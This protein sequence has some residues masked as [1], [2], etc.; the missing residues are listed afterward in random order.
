MK[1]RIWDTLVYVHHLCIFYTYLPGSMLYI[2]IYRSLCNV[3]VRRD[4][5]VPRTQ[6]NPPRD[7]AF[8][9]TGILEAPMRSGYRQ[10]RSCKRLV[11]PLGKSS[12]NGEMWK[13]RERWCCRKEDG[14]GKGRAWWGAWGRREGVWVGC[15]LLHSE[16]VHYFN[17]KC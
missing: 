13:K 12:R 16:P 9:V 3:N 1:G 17:L 15:Q 10:Y 7:E 6:S 8:K 5:S 4:E 11:L 2:S 14:G